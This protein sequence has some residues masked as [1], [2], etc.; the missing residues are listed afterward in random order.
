M[1]NSSIKTIEIQIADLNLSITSFKDGTVDGLKKCVAGEAHI[2]RRV[3]L[4]AEELGKLRAL[5]REERVG[6]KVDEL[7]NS[8]VRT[9]SAVAMELCDKAKGWATELRRGRARCGAASKIG[10]LR[11]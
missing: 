10:R 11:S 4:I 8:A 5:K 6:R 9:Q 2:R 7:T 1:K 3:A